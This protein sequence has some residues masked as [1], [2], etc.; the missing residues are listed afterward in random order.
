[1]CL[2]KQILWDDFGYL[3]WVEIW[4]VFWACC[5]LMDGLCCVLGMGGERWKEGGGWWRLGLSCFSAHV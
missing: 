2:C 1:V 3:V 4:D 5:I